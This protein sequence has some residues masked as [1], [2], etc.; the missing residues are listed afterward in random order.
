M[1]LADKRDFDSSGLCRET[2]RGWVIVV[3]PMEA[4]NLGSGDGG[5]VLPFT[6]VKPDAG[7]S[8]KKPVFING[9]CTIDGMADRRKAGAAEGSLT[10]AFVG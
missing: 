8:L 9:A 10:T 5:E 1:S 7:L 4:L 3:I 6:A 2:G